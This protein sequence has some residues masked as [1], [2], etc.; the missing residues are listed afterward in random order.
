MT[1]VLAA[2][3]AKGVFLLTSDDSRSGFE[4]SSPMLE[5]EA[6]Y[7]V[8]IDTRAGRRRIFAGGGSWHW[9]PQVRHTDDFGATW[10][11]PRERAIAFPEGLDGDPS[12]AQVW[13]VQPSTDA[14]P[15][16]VYAGVEPSALFRSEDGG[17]TFELVEGLWNHPH[18]PEWTP[19]G[20]GK[21]L[22][23]VHVDPRDPNRL[24]IAMSTGGHYRSDD[25]GSTWQARNKGI[26]MAFM[27]EG[28]Q[29]L[30]FGQC[31]HKIARDATAPDT[32]YLQHHWGIYRSDDSGDTWIDVGKGA[33]PDTGVPS[34][35]GFPVVTHPT[36]AGTAYVIPLQ[37]DGFR[38]TP[39]GRCRVYRTSDSGK[40]WEAL[41][42]GLPQT[43]AH[44]TVLRDGFCTDAMS[45]AGLY[46]GTRTGQIFGSNDDGDS[47]SLLVENLPP[48]LSVRAAQVD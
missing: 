7:S 37:S 36:R 6:I 33:G 20:G 32:F 38:V 11:Q 30:E 44:L 40:S 47:W 46:F 2:G 1:T 16:V 35:F 18:R 19:G 8:G 17:E 29:E 25:R 28:Q 26:V 23:T 45:P 39:E 3:T 34:D 15:D 42:E 22:H 12:V 10:T 43:D 41:T 48:V 14:E 5:G 31:V 21:C 24:D 13:Q 4:V 27:P 9:G